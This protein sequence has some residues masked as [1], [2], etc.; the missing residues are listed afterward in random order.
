MK[1]GMSSCS[2]NVDEEL[3]A[4]YQKAGVSMMEISMSPDQYDLLD[5]AK[6]LAL[7]QQ[8]GVELWSYH[9]PFSPFEILDIS[10]VEEEKRI[11]SVEREK[12]LI[13]RANEMQIKRCIIH[14]SGEPIREEERLLRMAQAKKSLR[15]LAEEAD[16]YGMVIC[17]EDLPRTC[18]GRNSSDML[19]LLSADDRLVSCFDTN[20]LLKE[21]FAD[22]LDKVGAYRGRHEG[23]PIVT[24]HV[25]D[26]DFVDEKHWLP[27]E[28]QM[29]WTGL[30]EK[31]KEIGYEGPWMYEVSPSCSTLKRDHDLTCEDFVANAKAIGAAE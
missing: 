27:G 1:I 14:A 24:L 12:E 9:L 3:F 15:E 7:S 4:A 13:R 21:S 6:T 11:S 10:A 8:Y 17:V 29:D 5:S 2:K 31:L 28:G 16:K 26:Y 19:E 18:L 30:I 23:C 20:H 25:S 22:Y